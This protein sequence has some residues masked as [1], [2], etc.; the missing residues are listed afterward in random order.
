MADPT[1]P[2]PHAPLR[3]AAAWG[4]HL[5]T[6]SGVVWALL[7][8]LAVVEGDNRAA[9]L[10]LTLATAVDSIDGTLARA[11]GVKTYAPGVDGALMDNIVDYMTWTFIPVLMMLRS[12]WLPEPGL[13]YAGAA[14][15]GSLFAFVRTD[16]KESDK[17]FFAG[18]PSYWNFVAFYVAVAQ[19]VFTPAVTGAVVLAL[20]ALSVAPVRFIYPSRVPRGRWFWVG[21]MWLSAPLWLWMFAQFPSPAPWLLALTAVYPVAYLVG[22]VWMDVQDRRAARG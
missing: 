14:L 21:G 6:A 17:G 4:V 13:F 9:F 12:G 1:I 3:V 2:T 18:F 7:A 10:W 15:V 8:L 16:A 5:F 19:S 22:S 11:V 20:A